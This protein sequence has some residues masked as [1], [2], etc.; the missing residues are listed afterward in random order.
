[1]VR[2]EILA[3]ADIGLTHVQIDAGWHKGLFSDLTVEAAKPR[4]PY[5]VDPDF[6]AIHPDK[7]PRGFEPVIEAAGEQGIGLGLWFHPDSTNDYARWE[8]DAEFVLSMYRQYGFNPVKIDGVKVMSKR[9]EANLLAFFERL[10]TG[11]EGRLCVNFDI[12]GGKSR[13]IGH[14]Y[15]TEQTGNLFIENRYWTNRTYYPW[16]TLRNLWQLCKYF[17]SYRLQMEFCDVEKGREKYGDD[18]LRPEVFGTEYGCACTLFAN[19]LC[20]MEAAQL[21][22]EERKRLKS[23]VSAY[24]PH[25]AAI[26][27]GRVFP[28]G[29]EPCGRAWTGLQSVH[30][31]GEGY[32]IV[33]RELTDRSEGRFFLCSIAPG[34]ALSLECVAGAHPGGEL[35]PGDDGE[36]MLALPRP[37]SYALLKYSQDLSG[38]A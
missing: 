16:R 14:F 26:L 37:A 1:M 4:G 9:G 7:F 33:F 6:Y 38:S 35:V 25:Q 27:Q 24:R 8:Q 28:M 20:W 15:G 19:P 18:L 36:I 23:L 11:S 2:D 32:L 17:P 34:R 3:A 29:E 22:A 10:H 12:T 13:R 21:G 5:D 31:E 30:G